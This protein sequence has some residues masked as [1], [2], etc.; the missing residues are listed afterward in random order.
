[1]KR[2]LKPEAPTK[3]EAS[4]RLLI[5]FVECKENPCRGQMFTYEKVNFK[6]QLVALILKHIF[7]AR[8]TF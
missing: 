7:T 4:N 3:A 1:M 6:K 5:M 2:A 8:K